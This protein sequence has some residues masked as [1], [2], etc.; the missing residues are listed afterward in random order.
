MRKILPTILF[1]L[2]LTVMLRALFLGGY[3]DFNAYYNGAMIGEISNYPPF[4]AILFYPFTFTSIAI[5]SKIWVVLSVFFLFLSLYLCFKL[6]NIQFLSSTALILLS[7]A[8]TYFPVKFTLGLGQ[9]N[10]LVLLFVVLTFY[11]YIKDRD[12]YSGICLGISIMLKLFP[13]LL[14]IYFLLKKRYKIL[15]YTAIAFITIAGIGCLLIGPEKNTNYWLHLSSILGSTP[16]D[17]YNQSLSG[18]LARQVNNI[19]LRGSLRIMISTFF[20]LV[21]FLIIFKKRKKYFLSK[22]LEFGLLIT[23]NVFINGYSWQ[24]HFVWL[25]LPFLIVFFYI[26]NKKLNVNNYLFLGI[27][28]LL[29][30]TNLK[31]PTMYP[32]IIQ[33]H[34][35]FGAILLWLMTAY[36]LLKND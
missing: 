10:L 8:F 16:V 13:V 3:L 35:F 19:S 5:A 36:L 12:C 32:P 31:N 1:T 11:F 20:I 30:G 29:T 21:S 34:I 2:A 9:L 25:I 17:Y 18:F 33:S 4:V 6:F 23:L 24:H 15:L 22:T 14:L 7:L 27:S 28:Y 26:K